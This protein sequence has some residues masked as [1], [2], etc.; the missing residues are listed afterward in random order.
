M[1]I[2]DRLYTKDAQALPNGRDIDARI[3][4]Y[5]E[6]T[7]NAYAKSGVNLRLRLVYKQLL[8]WADYYDVSSANLNKFTYDT[9]V[10]RL[11]EQ[12]GAD[13]VQLI[14]RT[15]QGQGYGVCGI[16]WMGTGP[17]NSDRFNSGAKEMAYGLT[18]VDC[19]LSTLSLIHI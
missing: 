17:K 15:T 8:D 12:Y 10:Q 16:A 18:G 13:L 6:Y 4:S 2:R 7:N 3:A 19:S 5:I 14:N 1:C 9:R 11:R